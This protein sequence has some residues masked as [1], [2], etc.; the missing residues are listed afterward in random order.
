VNDTPLLG[1]APAFKARIRLF[2]LR[3]KEAIPTPLLVAV[4][5]FVGAEAAFLIGRLSDMSFAP[6][7]PPN[8]VLFCALLLAPERR[9]WI[10]L[11]AAFPAHVL[12][13]LQVGMPTAH[14]LVAFSTT[15]RWRY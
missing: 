8:V 13:E 3:L 1:P 11:V 12:A 14:L 9:W 7:W 10:Y 6:F 4:A 15:A 2:L 5:Y